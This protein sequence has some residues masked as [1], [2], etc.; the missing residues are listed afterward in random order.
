MELAAQLITTMCVI[1]GGNGAID[2]DCVANMTKCVAGIH[3][4]SKRAGTPLAIDKVALV[5][6]SES[7]VSR[8]KIC[9]PYLK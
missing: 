8:A 4:Y 9:K 7:E 1:F 3:N 6:H 5:L 2:K